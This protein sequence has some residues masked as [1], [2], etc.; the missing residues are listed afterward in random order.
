MLCDVW[1]CM[2]KHEH[3]T[4]YSIYR[5]QVTLKWTFFWRLIWLE[6]ACYHH[7]KSSVEILVQSLN[8]KQSTI[9]L[10]PHGGPAVLHLVIPRQM[11]SAL[12]TPQSAWLSLS[13]GK[14]NQTSAS[15]AGIIWKHFKRTV[16]SNGFHRQTNLST[17]EKGKEQ[18]GLSHLI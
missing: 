7:S 5:N 10:P 16:W 12:L 15:V 2:Y 3:W 18:V 17:V 9:C 4:P 6:W 8:C 13:L 14:S 11:S 1:D